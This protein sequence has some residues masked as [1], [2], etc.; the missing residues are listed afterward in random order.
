MSRGSA[1]LLAAVALLAQ[2]AKFDVASVKPSAPDRQPNSNFPLGPGDVYV[3]NGGY[4]NAS[5]FPLITYMAFAYKL[6][7]NQAQY[8]LPQL[9]DWARNDHYDIQARAATDPGKDGMRLMVRALLAD[10]FGLVTHYEDREVPVLA[11]TLPA[12]SKTGPQLHRHSDDSPCP[13]EAA[14][15]DAGVVNGKPAFCNGIYPLKP[16]VPGR[17]RFGGRNVTLAFIADTFSAGVKL[18]RPIIDQTG[19]TGTFDFTLEWTQDGPPSAPSAAAEPP[20]ETTGPT[21]EEALRDQ[22][23]LKLQARKGPL[24]VLVVDHVEPPTAN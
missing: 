17:L 11:F 13:T 21:F 8:V 20:T 6:I 23:G 2:P 24:R 5:G 1:L 7:G 19:L 16:T 22:L 10:R 18:G 12:G 15:T 3:R 9:P 14:P 4:F